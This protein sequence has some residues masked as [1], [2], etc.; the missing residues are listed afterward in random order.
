MFVMEVPAASVKTIGNAEQISRQL[1][2]TQTLNAPETGKTPSSVR[3]A[4]VADREICKTPNN[5]TDDLLQHAIILSS[6]IAGLFM[7]YCGKGVQGRPPR[8]MTA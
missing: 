1:P 7:G 3:V 4:A 8:E 2:R 6:D 5:G